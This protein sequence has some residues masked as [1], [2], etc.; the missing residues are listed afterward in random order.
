MV[1]VGSGTKPRLGV[2]PY[3]T[4]IRGRY[5]SNSSLKEARWSGGND[6]SNAANYWSLVSSYHVRNDGGS[7]QQHM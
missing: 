3:Q 7:K 1:V 6:R 5:M 2:P 4:A